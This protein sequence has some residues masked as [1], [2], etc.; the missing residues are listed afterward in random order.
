MVTLEPITPKRAM[1]LK[2]L[3]L[4]ALQEAPEAFSSTYANESQINDAAWVIRAAQWSNEKSAGYLAMDDGIACGI[5]C[6]LLD[7]IDRSRGHLLS[8]WVAP[9]HRRLG[10]GRS[11]VEAILNWAGTQGVRTLLLQV[12]SNND[13]AITFYRRLGFA[14]TGRTEPYLNDPAL[15]NLEMAR[16]I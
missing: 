12:T 4:R 3:R 5:A 16:P 15:L 6:G 10:I 1:I 9:S 14:M 2:D 13:A 8:M 11:L 7:G